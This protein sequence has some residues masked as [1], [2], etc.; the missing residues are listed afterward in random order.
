M[1]FLIF[2]NMSVAGCPLDV[3]NP[4]LLLFLPLIIF[5]FPATQVYMPF[6]FEW[7][8]INRRHPY[9]VCYFFLETWDKH[10]TGS[11]ESVAML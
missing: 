9:G 8:L 3:K 5:A 7:V 2:K 4:T 6:L 1:I 11:E 10:L